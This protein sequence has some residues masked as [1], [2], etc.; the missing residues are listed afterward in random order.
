[1]WLLMNI[2][3]KFAEICPLV[4]LMRKNVDKNATDQ[5]TQPLTDPRF[6]GV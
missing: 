3:T 2:C 6:V 1:M 5:L 4:N